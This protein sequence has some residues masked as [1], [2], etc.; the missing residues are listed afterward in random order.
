MNQSI[1]QAS[2]QAII[3][4]SKPSQAGKPSQAITQSAK[5]PGLRAVDQEQ[6]L[7]RTCDPLGRRL[8][9]QQERGEKR[10][11]ES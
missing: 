10:N 11:L 8:A 4:T 7:H 6:P 5:E 1:N 9:R 3:Q 2:K